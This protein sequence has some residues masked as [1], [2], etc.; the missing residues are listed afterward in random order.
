MIFVLYGMNLSTNTNRKKL[1]GDRASRITSEELFK[2]S[3]EVLS[4]SFSLF[5][6]CDVPQSF[7]EKQTHGD[8]DIVAIPYSTDWVASFSKMFEGKILEYSANGQ[9][10]SFLFRSD[11]VGK[12]VHVDVI[13]VYREFFFRAMM[14][15]YSYNDLSA[16]IGII[17]R[18][19][20]FKYSTLG[21]YKRYKDAKGNNHTI[22]LSL[23]LSEGLM[24]LGYDPQ[25][26][27]GIRSLDDA[28]AFVQSSPFFDH[29][30]F[31]YDRMTQKE[32]KDYKRPNIQAMVNA[33]RTMSAE[34]S[35]EDDDH[36]V[37]SFFPNWM[38]RIEKRIQRIEKGVLYKPVYNGYWLNQH[39]PHIHGPE[40]RAVLDEIRGHFGFDLARTEES[41]VINHI[42]LFLNEASKS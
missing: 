22:L 33:F 34:S 20:G 30:D 27:L 5:R 41:V 12:D 26:F 29:R 40:L 8:V 16:V 18:R 3:T 35:V 42:Q 1:F 2:V 11:S 4:K 15:Y 17:A 14:H 19:R 36:F 23:R 6:M 21:F 25:K 38:E 32:K 9:C 13:V 31:L 37:K 7:A 24:A 39:F 10:H 28:I